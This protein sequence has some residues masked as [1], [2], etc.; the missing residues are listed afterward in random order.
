VES[1]AISHFMTWPDGRH[2]VIEFA[3]PGDVVGLG[4]ASTHTST[5]LAMVDTL[6]SVLTPAEMEGALLTDDVLAMRQTAA[7]DREFDLLR[8]RAIQG[9]AT[10]PARRLAHFLAAVTH[11]NDRSCGQ[12]GF[13]SDDSCT[14]YV[15]NLLGMDMDGLAKALLRLQERDLIAA[16]PGGLRIADLSALERFAEAG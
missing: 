8:E 7:G 16:V 2:D 14:P 12:P 3:F 11:M 5:A 9:A 6:V 1:G 15:A 4:Y 10:D 13:V